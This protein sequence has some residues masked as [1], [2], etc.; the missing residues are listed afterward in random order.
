MRDSGF[1]I[2]YEGAY[3]ELKMGKLISLELQ[4]TR[5]N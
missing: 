1:E 5:N 4:S 3:M 2:N